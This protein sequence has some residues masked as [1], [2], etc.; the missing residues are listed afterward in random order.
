MSHK[1]STLGS[2]YGNGSV[3]QLKS[4]KRFSFEELKKYTNN[5]SEGKSIGTG[6]YGKS[7]STI[8]TPFMSIISTQLLSSMGTPSIEYYFFLAT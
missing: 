5:F 1:C 6:G 7:H 8:P 4:A 2:E 3:P